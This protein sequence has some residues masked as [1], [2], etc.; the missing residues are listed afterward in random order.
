MM[1]KDSI[2]AWSCKKDDLED[3]LVRSVLH[4]FSIGDKS[5][6]FRVRDLVYLFSIYLRYLKMSKSYRNSNNVC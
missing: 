5:S 1:A 6:K 3:Q 4:S 2:I